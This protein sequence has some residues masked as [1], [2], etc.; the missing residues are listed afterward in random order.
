MIGGLIPD[1]TLSYTPVPQA[2]KPKFDSSGAH[3]A[4]AGGPPRIRA[5]AFAPRPP[6]LPSRPLV[7]TGFAVPR[8]LTRAARPSTRFVFL[9]PWLC[10]RLPSDSASRRTPLPLA[11][12]RRSPESIGAPRNLF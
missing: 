1:Q 12:E 9:R 10:L 3:T 11:N 5:P 8:Q 6:R 4:E 2:P 7:A